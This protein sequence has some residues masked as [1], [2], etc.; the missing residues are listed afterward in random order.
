[1]C[2]CASVFTCGQNIQNFENSTSSVREPQAKQTQGIYTSLGVQPDKTAGMTGILS[3][4]KGEIE[5]QITKANPASL[6]LHNL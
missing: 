2:L 1:M 6:V 3:H 5:P 4:K